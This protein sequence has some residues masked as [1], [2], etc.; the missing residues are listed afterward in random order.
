MGSGRAPVGSPGPAPATL[1]AKIRFRRAALWLAAAAA[2]PLLAA[3]A[4][5]KP[6]ERVLLI[7][8]DHLGDLLFSTPALRLLRRAWPAA[9]ITYLVG[10]W[11][12][13]VVSRNPCVDR[14]ITCEFPGFGSGPKPSPLHP[15]LHLW[16]WAGSLRREGYD[17]ALNLRYDFWWGAALAFLARI[18]RRVGYAIPECQP[19]LSLAVP[20]EAGQHAV[21][22]NLRLAAAAA[23]I[24]G[25][26]WLEAQSYR[27][28]FPLTP[29][30]RGLALALLHRHGWKQGDVLVGIHPGT[31]G[32][33]KHWTVEGWQAVALALAQR[34]TRILLTGT[35]AEADTCRAIA[36]GVPGQSIVAAGET[37]L[38]QLAALLENCAVVLGVDSGPLHLAVA[39][40]VPTVHLYGPSDPITFGPYGDP[41]RHIVL[42]TDWRCSPCHRFEYPQGE[43]KYHRCMEAIPPEAVLA[44]A[45]RLLCG[46]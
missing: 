7:R 34:G 21:E 25:P 26:V 37:S 18:P 17:L 23:Q 35:A 40:G 10:P 2:R 14:V 13:A 36:A 39:V 6:P 22:G 44:A 29:A 9:H 42:R 43:L 12:E 27:L 33:V 3:A 41:A 19:F 4:S 38:G 20:F 15:Y 24:P 30:E 1:G 11:A 16:R 5:R 31:R 28:D 46:R 45:E 8:P 32:N